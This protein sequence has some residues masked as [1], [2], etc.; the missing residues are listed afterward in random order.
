MIESLLAYNEKHV[1][2]NRA[3]C[4]TKVMPANLVVKTT[5]GDKEVCI[6]VINSGATVF[7]AECET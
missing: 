6:G 7:A 3:S 5:D 1:E 2:Y 4:G